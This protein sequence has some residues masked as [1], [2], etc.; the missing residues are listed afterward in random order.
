[1]SILVL[2]ASCSLVSTNAFGF[3]WGNK[4]DSDLDV[5]QDRTTLA[6][7]LSTATAVYFKGIVNFFRGSSRNI[8]IKILAAR[9]VRS[10][11]RNLS[12]CCEGFWRDSRHEK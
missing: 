3:G 1:M 9:T 12:T 7:D 2:V 10:I 5:S 4:I 8:A 11:L 6:D